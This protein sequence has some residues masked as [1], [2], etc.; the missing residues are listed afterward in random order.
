MKKRYILILFIAILLFPLSVNA[1]V[2]Q[3]TKI[4]VTDEAKLL[5]E[6]TEDYIV[7]YSS[8]LDE[9]C[10]IKVMVVA[11][12]GI[13][14]LT[15]EEYSDMVYESHNVT[16]EGVLILVSEN[17][18]Q[19]RIQVGEDLSLLFPDEKLDEYMSKY[20]MPYFKNGEWQKGIKNGYSAIY[21]TI[22]QAFDIDATE[23]DVYEGDSFIN[24]YKYVIV[25]I[26]VLIGTI[27]SNVF[28]NYLLN[29]IRINK[30]K[31]A[32]DITILI[33]SVIIN[34][35]LIVLL[36]VI[37]PKSV[38]IM[39]TTELLVGYSSYNLYKE[40]KIPKKEHHKVN[41]IPRKK[42]MRSQNVKYNRAQYMKDNKFKK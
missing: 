5:D 10:K 1:I 19:F 30:N 4:Y 24:K 25:S 14:D 22:C 12:S 41:R 6:E 9:A 2:E 39:L 20:M 38:I 13:D 31:D 34:I 7:K 40:A 11:V 42:L 26:I 16:T 17:S 21:K 36:Y 27:L 15:I 35:F 33:L 23:M 29:L 37:V 3:S 8:F 28:A 18:H 32:F